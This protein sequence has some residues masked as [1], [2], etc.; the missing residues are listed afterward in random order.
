MKGI[1]PAI[2]GTAVAVLLAVMAGCASLS[3]PP[4][5]D[6]AIRLQ[7][8]RTA[9]AA[10]AL[11]AMERIDAVITIDSPLLG[12]AISD[13]LERVLPGELSAPARVHF[14][15]Q[16]I[17]FT[18]GEWNGEI[19]LGFEDD[20]ITWQAD[21]R[22]PAG[23]V[24]EHGS[25]NRMA[26][27]LAPLGILEAGARFSGAFEGVADRSLPL[28][29]WPVMRAGALLVQPDNTRLAL[30]LAFLA[31]VRR[32]EGAGAQ[33]GLLL[34]YDFVDGNPTGVRRLDAGAAMAP[35]ATRKGQQPWT[36]YFVDAGRECLVRVVREQPPRVVP[37]TTGSVAFTDYEQAFGAATAGLVDPGHDDA[38][39]S[40][41]MARSALA[42]ALRTALVDQSI[43]VSLQP[44]GDGSSRFSAAMQAPS[45]DELSC[46]SSECTTQQQ[47]TV[48]HE[49]CPLLRDTRQCTVCSLRNP[50]N[51][52]C[53]AEEQDTECL[54]ARD[55]RNER[56]AQERQACIAVEEEARDACL[57]VRDQA[58]LQCRT[59]R[60]QR[61]DQCQAAVERVAA[62]RPSAPGGRVDMAIRPS[63]A[64]DVRFSGFSVD[65]SL[66]QLR[67]AVDVAGN[68]ELAGEMAFTPSGDLAGA[69]P[70]TARW[71]GDF[72]TFADLATWDGALVS[73]LE[74]EGGRLVARWS[75][76]ARP[77]PLSP[78][79]IRALFRVQPGLLAGCQAGMNAAWV[80]RALSGEQAG[81]FQGRH[82]LVTQP[83]PTRVSLLPGW[84]TLM[85]ETLVAEPVMGEASV[86]FDYVTGKD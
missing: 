16:L 36:G 20:A 85:G 70:C 25:G 86:R 19:L 13:W 54:Q 68:L 75:G 81:V 7:A 73:P 23:A 6:R 83:L 40:M 33:E 52:R 82:E 38:P 62:L 60:Q 12:S 80:E 32:C 3:S 51:N 29:A 11:A 45:A 57:V 53:L 49:N 50:L 22:A 24:L 43:A 31:G 78:S 58:L 28:T 9:E 64:L 77:V 10:A 4:L 18:A 44:R 26:F 41:V 63:G 72:T 35:P 37:A 8:E 56:M 39:V 67:M 76:L 14:H 59:Q 65:A 69:L 17:W 5:D 79:P 30:D 74:F 48:S 84:V 42:T 15:D 2:R 55:R 47:C 66:Q 71:K 1:T 21:V 61:L 27:D 34:V 46:A